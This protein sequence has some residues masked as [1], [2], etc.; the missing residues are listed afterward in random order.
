MSC[1]DEYKYNPHSSTCYRRFKIKK[2]WHEAKKHCEDEG[3]YFA[4]LET[5]ESVKWLTDAINATEGKLY[6]LLLSHNTCY[7]GSD[8]AFLFVCSRYTSKLL[9]TKDFSV[10]VY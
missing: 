5:L 2:S 10:F 3:E 6:I 9:F 7:I 8:A 4:T 1:P